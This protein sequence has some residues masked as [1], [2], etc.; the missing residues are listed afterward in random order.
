[1][2]RLFVMFCLASLSSV[3]LHAQAK[4]YS[5]YEDYCADNPHAPTCSN[6]KPLKYDSSNNPL[7]KQMEDSCKK[8][9]NTPECK[10]WCAKQPGSPACKPAAK[11]GPA[12]QPQP[13]SAEA[14]AHNSQAAQAMRARAHSGP[15]IIELPGAPSAAQ[16]ATVKTLG[17]HADWRFA[18]PHADML[19]GVNAAALRQSPTLRALLLQL[20]PSLKLTADDVDSQLAQIGDIDQLWFSSHSSDPVILLLGPRAVAPAGP[21]NLSNGMVAYGVSH[22]A[23]LIGHPA[24]AAAAV[25]RLR[26]AGVPTA[27]A[28]QMK[29]Q[30]TESDIW[31]MGT[32]ATL[33]QTKLPVS[34]VSDDLSGFVAGMSLHDGLKFD[35]KLNYANAASARPRSRGHS[36][37][38]ASTRMAHSCD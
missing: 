28:L 9:P 29:A 36:E 25:Q 34:G 27:A 13:L 16:L 12:P 5:T 11:A 22:G 1:M 7:L 24:A 14:T 17:L 38:P 18:D 6:G 30:S 33:N 21:T 35:L 19:I 15:S 20:A 31:V 3:V 37:N 23:V 26:A 8:L 32:R 4:S 2:K 10:D